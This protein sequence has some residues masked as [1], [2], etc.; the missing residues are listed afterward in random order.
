MGYKEERMCIYL[1]GRLTSV[2]AC[3]C[4]DASIW[5]HFT[6]IQELIRR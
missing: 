4:C 3:C 6:V 1:Q 5:L 2:F